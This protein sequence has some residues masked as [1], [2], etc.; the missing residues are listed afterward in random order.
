MFFGWD[1]K[2]VQGY[3]R[4]CAL[5]PEELG[6]KEREE[7]LGDKERESWYVYIGFSILDAYSVLRLSG[8]ISFLPSLSF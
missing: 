6:E 2:D 3:G 8:Q 5:R 7:E 4:G 1:K